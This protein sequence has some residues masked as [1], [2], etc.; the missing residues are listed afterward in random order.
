MK[1]ILLS[2]FVLTVA[3]LQA[4]NSEDIL[5]TINGKPVYVTE[6]ERM[7]TKNLDLVKDASQRDIDNY[8]KLFTNYRLELE[9]AYVKKYDTLPALQRELKTY[10][11]DL[12]KKYLS[13]ND[14]IDQL[15]KEA[16]ERMKQDV[17]VAHILIQVPQDAAPKDTLAAYHKIMA[18]YQ[19]AKNGADF[20]QLAQQYSEDPSAKTNKGDLDYINVFH[21]VYPFESAAYNTPVGS[22]SKPFRTRFGYHIVKVLDKRPAK[23]EIQVAHIM[24]MESKSGKGEQESAKGRIFTIYDKLKNKQDTFENLAI[25]YSDDRRSGKNGGRLNRFGIRSMVPEF[26]KQAFALEKP[27]DISEPF[28]TKYGWHIV[29][30]LKKYPVPSFEETEAKL[31]KKVLRDERSKMGKEKLMKKIAKEF[32][33][34]V[35]GSLEKVYKVVNKDFFENKWHIP[36]TNYN[37]KTLFTID[38]KK[39]ITYQDFFEYLYK[40]QY[41]NPKKYAKKDQLINQFFERFKKEKLFEYYNENLERIYPEFAQIMNEYKNGLMLFYIKSDEVWNKSIQDTLG[42]RKFYEAHK[43]NYRIPKKF[44]VVLIQANDKKTAK[45]IK[46]DLA[47]GKDIKYIQEHYKKHKLIIKE[48]EYDTQDAFVK[49][50]QLDKKKQVIYKDGNQYM[51]VYL[52]AEKPERIPELKEIKGKVTNDYQ[53]YLEQEWLKK[54]HQKYPVKTNRENWEKIR[55]KYKK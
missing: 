52:K 5:M 47:K 35:T 11:K 36:Q 27:N 23:G 6:F 21:T 38:G 44:V 31:R 32:P 39:N 50:H 51:I 55:A 17:H 20:G 53:A 15:V 46:K 2:I 12:A 14:L 48:K 22:V 40:R 28:Q 37:Q 41:R 9:D 29:K 1:K 54:L 10:R 42:I 43:E 4:Q 30:L 34:Q 26:E 8:K 19:K 25:K 33:I 7:Y 49:K 18:I 13:D 3:V 45:K 16:Y 24:T